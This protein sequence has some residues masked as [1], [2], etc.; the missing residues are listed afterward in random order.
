MTRDEYIAALKRELGILGDTEVSE[1]CSDF[2][3]HFAV[4]ISQGKTEHEI[5]AELGDPHSVAETYLSDNIEQA[6]GYRATTQSNA[7]VTNAV[8]SNPTVVKDLT[9][10]RL[11]VILFNILVMVWVAISVY[12]AILSFW[13]AAIGILIAAGAVLA[14]IP[15]IPSGA[16]LGV[17]LTGI[18]L[19]FLAVFIGIL[20][21]FLTKLAVIATKE[22]VKWNKKVYNEGF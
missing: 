17:V 13:A 6:S 11:F 19:F 8:A 21:F 16:V 12:S 22:Y 1:I 2:E 20:C 10:P 5:S 7:A 3:E 15:L 18:G 14:A 9:G 4:G